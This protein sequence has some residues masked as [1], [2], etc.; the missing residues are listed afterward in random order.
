MAQIHVRL[1]PNTVAQLAAAAARR[2]VSKEKLAAS[3]VEVSLAAGG[4]TAGVSRL[5]E[6]LT[7]HAAALARHDQALSEISERTIALVTA[8]ESIAAQINQ[9]D[10]ELEK[11]L[12]SILK[13]TAGGYSHLKQLAAA[14]AASGVAASTASPVSTKS[15]DEKVA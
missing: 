3:L 15:V 13:Y 12:T 8:A 5:H 1:E 11:V 7:D 10:S 6:R 4:D 14:L 9:L 2:S